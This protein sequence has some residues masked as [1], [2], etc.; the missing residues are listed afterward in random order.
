LVLD[1]VDGS[2]GSPVDGGWEVDLGEDLNV[3]VWVFL[4]TSESEELLVLGISPGGEVVVSDGE[5][6]LWDGVDL[7]VL[8]ILL[9]EDG[10]SEVVLLLGSVGETELGH[11][12]DEGTLELWGDERGLFVTEGGFKS[13][14]SGGFAE[15]LHL[16][17]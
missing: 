2:L 15:V 14:V 7:L 13:E 6:V 10:K 16:C 5:G 8:G 4:L 12:L 3:G 9:G 11:V 17:F 1:W